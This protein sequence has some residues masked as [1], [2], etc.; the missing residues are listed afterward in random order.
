[1]LPRR[2]WRTGQRNPGKKHSMA[3]SSSY[4]LTGFYLKHSVL[5]GGSVGIRKRQQKGDRLNNLIFLLLI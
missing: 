1:M 3:L 2:S 5:V 4:N